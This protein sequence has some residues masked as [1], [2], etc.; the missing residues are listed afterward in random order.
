[1]NTARY[2]R[3]TVSLRHA[4]ALRPKYVLLSFTFLGCLLAVSILT[5]H[6]AYGFSEFFA[7]SAF[8]T[9]TGGQ[10]VSFGAMLGTIFGVVT[11]YVIKYS[12]KKP[13]P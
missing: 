9:S 10:A 5:I 8:F 7:E 2:Q 6:E 3:C 13:V 11:V 1:M 12:R 4:I